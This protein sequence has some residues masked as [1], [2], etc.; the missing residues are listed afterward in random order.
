M[1]LFMSIPHDNWSM[2]RWN[3]VEDQRCVFGGTEPEK[4]GG[5]FLSVRGRVPVSEREFLS[6]RECFCLWGG[7]FLSLRESSCLWE[8]VP[9]SERE[10]LSVRESS[11]LWERVSVCK[12]PSS[13]LWGG[14]F[15][16][17]RERS[18]LWGGEF[19]SLRESYCLWGGEFLS[20]REGS[21]RWGAKFLSISGRITVCERKILSLRRRVPV[22]EKECSCLWGA[23]FLSVRECSCLWV[24]EFLSVE[25]VFLSVRGRVPVCDRVFLSVRGWVPVCERVFL[26][27]RGRVPVCERVFLSVRGRVTVCERELLSVRG[28]VP[29]CES[30]WD[31]AVSSLLSV[32]VTLDP[33]SA[34]PSL[35]LSENRKQVWLGPQ[36]QDVLDSPMRFNYTVCI[37]AQEGF[38]S[39]LQYWEVGTHRKT[40]WTVGVAT[41]SASRKGPIRFLPR[42]GY[43]VIRMQK[44]EVTA[45][46]EPPLP[47][48]LREKP[49]TVGVFLDYEGGQVSFYSVETRTHI[50]SFTGCSFTQQLYPVFRPGL[51]EMGKNSAPLVISPVTHFRWLRTHLLYRKPLKLC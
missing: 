48:P 4:W 2:Y 3:Y 34:H 49:R 15:L 47:L 44:G 21:C 46:H 27:V 41:S 35:V 36:R 19:L 39:G 16:S 24:G 26:F 28:R 8:R 23:E 20:V 9:V 13:Y 25:R 43:W 50:Y 12:G 40:G 51:T 6:V 7:E 32:D 1:Y 30:W 10:F 22:C 18:C 31:W 38:S 17:V 29:V 33:D 42:A 14:E 37:L 45:M 11:C 5:E